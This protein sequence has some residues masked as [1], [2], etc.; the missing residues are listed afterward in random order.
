MCLEVGGY[1]VPGESSGIGRKVQTAKDR[2]PRV[3]GG[4][5]PPVPRKRIGLW[6]KS[7]SD[8][9]R[10]AG[11]KRAILPAAISELVAEIGRLS[12]ST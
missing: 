8:E 2:V 12:E 5:K 7:N 3:S 9:S 1:P 6:P 4:G 10:S 11:V